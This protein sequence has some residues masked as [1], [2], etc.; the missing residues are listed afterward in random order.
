[1][2]KRQGS[3]ALH[4]RLTGGLRGV[5]GVNV[6][7]ILKNRGAYPMLNIRGSVYLALD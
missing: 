6:G 3:V 5:G 1:M 7:T 4:A 2:A